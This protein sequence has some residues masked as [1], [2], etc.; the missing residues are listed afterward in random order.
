M[1]PLLMY[2]YHVAGIGTYSDGPVN[3]NFIGQ[4][5][6]SVSQTIDSGFATTF[7]AHV[8]A[9]Y[10]FLMRYYSEGDRIYI[11]GFSRG[12]F[13]ARFLARLVSHVGLLSMGNE[14]M[15]PFAYKVYQ[16]YA[17]GL[18]T[19]EHSES[20]KPKPTD[21]QAEIPRK[22]T[23]KSEDY[24]E[25]FREAFCRHGDNEGIKVQFLG[26]FD[27]VS[28]VRAFDVPFGAKIEAPVVQGTAQCIRH[29]VSIDERRVKFKAAL[30]S[31]DEPAT[32]EDVKEV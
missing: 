11:F 21:P 26:L 32:G 17:M 6:R 27:T 13:T 1:R 3:Q 15:V 25:A 5:K 30:L 2:F 24:M 19:V 20:K 7:D 9:G 22:L 4:I 29:A 12:A 23:T 14:E 18:D 16:D 31:Q 8:I 10:R 28:S